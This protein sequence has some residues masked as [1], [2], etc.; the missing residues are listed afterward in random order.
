M[1]GIMT[2]LH[3]I[4]NFVR[5]ALLLIPLPVVRLLFL[6]TLVVL[7]V[8]VLRLPRAETTP[9][10]GARRWDQNLKVGAAAA[11][12]IQIVLYAWL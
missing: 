8:W 1:N 7:L 2:L 4:G 6:A 3:H 10:E 5:N 9:A 12:L 11:L